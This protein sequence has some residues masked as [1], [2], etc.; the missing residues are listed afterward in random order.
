M[1]L[2]DGI[3]SPARNADDLQWAVRAVVS[4]TQT[5]LQGLQDDLS[6]TPG[7]GLSNQ[8]PRLVGW[9][10]VRVNRA[11]GLLDRSGHTRIPR[12]AEVASLRGANT[13]GFIPFGLRRVRVPAHVE[14]LVA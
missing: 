7:H 12:G 10:P 1:V 14:P 13:I 3:K 2:P 6:V 8:R 9:L 4:R 5:K 11:H